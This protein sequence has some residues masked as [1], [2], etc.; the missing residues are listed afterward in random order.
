MVTYW[1]LRALVGEDMTSTELAWNTRLS[2]TYILPSRT[3]WSLPSC[4]WL[5]IIKRLTD[6]P[7]VKINRGVWPVCI[8]DKV[9]ASFLYLTCK[10]L[11]KNKLYVN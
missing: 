3:T 7:R 10:N 5:T 11:H 2:L 4:V 6:K 9:F 1:Q 8:F